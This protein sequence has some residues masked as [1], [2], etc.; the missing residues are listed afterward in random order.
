MGSAWAETTKVSQV[1][2][3]KWTRLQKWESRAEEQLNRSGEFRSENERQIITRVGKEGL[4][5]EGICLRLHV[6]LPFTNQPLVLH[7]Q[8]HWQA[9]LCTSGHLN[10]VNLRVYKASN[11]TLAT[12]SLTRCLKFQTE[13][14]I[15][16]T[17]IWHIWSARYDLKQWSS[18]SRGHQ[19]HLESLSQ[20][21]LLGPTHQSFR[22]R[23]CGVR[24]NNLH[25]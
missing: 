9:G 22:L 6:C 24:H 15:V 3:R 2:E 17:C 11:N 4:G 7:A 23:R 25:A 20:H 16:T 5:W 8:W 18:N 12:T 13:V 10:T 21:R 1:K 14:N 19:K